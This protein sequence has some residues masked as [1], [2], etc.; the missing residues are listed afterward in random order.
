MAITAKDV[1]PF[2]QARARLSEIADEVKAGAEKI[3]TKNGE[4]YVALIDADRLDYYHRLERERI[5]LVLL[6]EA[7]HGLADVEQ[8]K[9]S[10]ARQS[11]RRRRAKRSA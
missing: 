11:I 5:H 8:G 9:V 6:E 10:D 3:I 4:S 1:V 7:A 2:S